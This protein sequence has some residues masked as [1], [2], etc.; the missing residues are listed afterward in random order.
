MDR[1]PASAS[2]ATL[3]SKGGVVGC[4]TTMNNLFGTGRIA[5][6]TGILL[7][8]SPN[9]ITPPLL[10]AGLATRDGRFRAIA[11]GSGQ[12]GAAMAVAAGLANAVRSNEPM[13]EPVPAPGRANVIGCAGLLPGA[14]KTCAAAADP[15][16]SG[17]AI[18]SN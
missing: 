12:Q 8:A 4:A 17:L 15:R 18:G 3:D 16:G 9:G 13:P 7:A 5:P 6:G 10:A 2:F 14:P 1:L 11:T